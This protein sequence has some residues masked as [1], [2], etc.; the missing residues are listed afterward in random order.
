MSSSDS[1]PKH[2]LQVICRDKHSVSRKAISEAALKV[3][4]RLKNHGYQA[5]L[6]G[7]AVRDLLLG[8]H[9]KDFDI[10]TD[11]HP[12]EV[13]A[14]FRN[15]RLIGRRF[16]LAHIRFGREI[17]EVATFRSNDPPLSDERDHH[18]DATG[19]ILRDNVYGDIDDDVLRRDFTA[20]A[21]YYNIADYSIWDYV[22]GVQDISSGTLRMIGDPMLRYREDPVRMLRAVR[23]AAK[24]G[25]NIEPASAQPLYELAHLLENVPPARLYD[26]CLKLFMA[27]GAE[28]AFELLREYGLFRYLFPQ[29]DEFLNSDTQDEAASQAL[30]LIRMATRSTDQRVADGKPVTPAFLIA[31]FLWPLVRTV[32]E[33]YQ[34]AGKGPIHSAV[35]ACDEVIA[36]QQNCVAV[37]KRTLLPIRE[38][39]VM[40]YRLRYRRGMRALRLLQHPRFRAAYDLLL[41]RCDT[42]EE[43]QELGEWWTAIQEM[44]ENA[45]RVSAKVSGSPGSKNSG[46]KPTRRRARRKRRSS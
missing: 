1:D 5:F 7:G 9:P 32:T 18:R 44:D 38:M 33:K 3:L 25:F 45:Q 20:N 41:L 27:G 14:L 46:R 28:R 22:N 36:A 8:G 43:Q 37:P 30:S 40:Q 23:F 21:L 4:Y 16:R 24:L 42:D 39:L 31:V 10:A 29:T 19:R 35:M 15:S 12:D 13:R 17:I 6:V 2:G 11:A 26:E 34:A